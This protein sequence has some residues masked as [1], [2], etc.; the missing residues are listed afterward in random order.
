MLGNMKSNLG[1]KALLDVAVPLA[2]DVLLK[3]A[4]EA[5]SCALDKCER[6]ISGKGVVK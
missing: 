4:T 5:T 6:K 2:K 3:L 1:K